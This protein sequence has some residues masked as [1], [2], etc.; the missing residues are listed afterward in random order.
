MLVGRVLYLPQFSST[1]GFNV[2]IVHNSKCFTTKCFTAKFWAA[3][4][5]LLLINIGL[6]SSVSHADTYQTSI[7]QKDFLAAIQKQ[8]PQF[9]KE[10]LNREIAESDL[11]IQGA[12]QEWE[13]KLKAQQAHQETLLS[14][15]GPEKVDQSLVG[16][17]VGRQ[18]WKTGAYVA[19]GAEASID[20]N[21][22]GSS[23]NPAFPSP[24]ESQKQQINLTISQPLL[25]N[26]GG[27]QNR[28][29]YDLSEQS[30]EL[31]ELQT[32]EAQ[33]QFLSLMNQEY[34]T[35]VSL[36]EQMQINEQRLNLASR[37]KDEIKKRYDKNVVERIDLLRS[38]D[39][40]RKSQQQYLLSKSQFVAKSFSLAR[41]SNIETLA[42]AKPDFLLYDLPELE[43]LD[44]LL[45]NAKN[46]SRVIRILDKQ[47]EQL[48]RRLRSLKDSTRPELNLDVSTAIKS[49]EQDGLAPGQDAKA[50]GQ[51]YSV[52]LNFK[53]MLGNK[54][55][56]GESQKL[57]YQLDQLMLEKQYA[58]MELDANVHNLYIQLQEMR[59][60]LELNKEL[61]KTAEQT[62][63]EEEKI[64]Q[65]GRSDLTNVIISRD[66]MQGARL[67]YA[68][69]AIN[70]HQLY[71]QLQSLTDRLLADQ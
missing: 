4:L 45:Q 17:S 56:Q 61:V 42:Q 26:F 44:S 57:Q 13:L 16:A 54:T 64:Y 22:Y 3:F 68:Q 55:A 32:R 35:W 2:K 23:A 7:S 65:Q 60:I 49:E 5:N 21:E 14:S 28:L 20:E 25:K 34:L 63:Q 39:T 6:V 33:E 47:N 29:S 40:E 38:Q 52:G 19:V 66:Q 58:Q 18:I 70:Y 37:Q 11:Q 12:A 59:T 9:Q 8:H 36:F 27:I 62:T 15:F 71:L 53:K 24:N 10:A 1:L 41:L 51:D 50:D 46:K 69:N 30:S 48:S 43:S 31:S 67:Q